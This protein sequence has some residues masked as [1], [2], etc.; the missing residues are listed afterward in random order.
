MSIKVVFLDV[1]GVLNCQATKDSIWRGCIGIDDNKLEQLKRIIDQTGAWIILSSSW[2]S[3]W[4]RID[5][6][7]QQHEGHYLDTKLKKFELYIHDK[8]SDGSRGKCISQW[9][10]NYDNIVEQFVILDDETFDFK[11]HGLLPN[12]VQTCFYDDNGGLTKEHADIAIDILNNGSKEKQ[13]FVD[14]FTSC[15]NCV[16]VSDCTEHESRDGCYF[17]EIEHEERNNES[18]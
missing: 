11:E 16:Y 12:L 6:T 14:N 5:K 13:Q 4:S 17:G 18:I 2:K 1:D 8:I 7:K 10:T 9:L 15:L 3:G